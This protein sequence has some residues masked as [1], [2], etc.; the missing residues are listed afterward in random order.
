[1]QW[2]EL[3]FSSGGMS[4]PPFPLSFWS[5]RQTVCST[6]SRSGW[7]VVRNASLAKGGTS[8]KR[9]SPHLQNV[10]TR[11]NKVSPRTFQTVLMQDVS[12]PLHSAWISSSCLWMWTYTSRLRQLSA[13]GLAFFVTGAHITSVIFIMLQYSLLRQSAGTDYI[14]QDTIHSLRCTVWK[15][16][17]NS[18]GSGYTLI[19]DYVYM[20]MNHWIPQGRVMLDESNDSQ[21]FKNTYHDRKVLRIVNEL[22]KNSKPLADWGRF[23]FP[24][25]W[26]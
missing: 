17:L 6:F 15:T 2:E 24:W 19:A 21:L 26:K 3:W 20:V 11:S 22:E 8:K 5:L 23:Q 4:K 1:M 10:P 14:L 7:S 9:P 16:G 13:V 18:T 25:A 12:R